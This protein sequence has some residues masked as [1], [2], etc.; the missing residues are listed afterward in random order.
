MNE[1]VGTC[2]WC[3]QIKAEHTTWPARSNYFQ[4]KSELTPIPGTVYE[5][6]VKRIEEDL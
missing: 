3:G 2:K 5:V 1:K 6:D 4:Y